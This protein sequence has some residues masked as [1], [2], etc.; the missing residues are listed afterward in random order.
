MA[1][2]CA[3]LLLLVTAVTSSVEGAQLSGGNGEVVVK[4]ILQK[5][6][7]DMQ[8]KYIKVR[9]DNCQPGHFAGAWL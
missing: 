9:G 4:D 1:A 6:L 7:E 8:L 3:C 5:V 2:L